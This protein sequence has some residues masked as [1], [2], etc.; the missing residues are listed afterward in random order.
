MARS[1]WTEDWASK[2]LVYIAVLLHIFSLITASVASN[3]TVSHDPSH[4]MAAPRGCQ[5]VP[6]PQL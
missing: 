5:T 1:I 2:S 6:V 3:G 4:A